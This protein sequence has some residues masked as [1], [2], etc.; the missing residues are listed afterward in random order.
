MGVGAGMCCEDLLLGV[1]A[2]LCCEELLLVVGAG[3][4]CVGLVLDIGAELGAMAR[5]GFGVTARL[6]SS[7]VAGVSSCHGD[8][9]ARLYKYRL[10]FAVCIPNIN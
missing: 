7:G 10:Q 4:C 8:A 1:G 5:L 6:M 2:G 9:G 3:L